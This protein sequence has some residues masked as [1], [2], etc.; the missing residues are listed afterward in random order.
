MRPYS[1]L[2]HS[3][4]LTNDLCAAR[5]I[6][7]GSCDNV[8]CIEDLRCASP[9]SSLLFVLYLTRNAFQQKSFEVLTTRRDDRDEF[10]QFTFDTT[11]GELCVPPSPAGLFLFVR[12]C[13][14]RNIETR[15]CV[16]TPTLLCI[17]RIS[18]TAHEGPPAAG[19][20]L[21]VLLK[22]QIYIQMGYPG[23]ARRAITLEYCIVCSPS[24]VL[25]PNPNKEIWLCF[26][27]RRGHCIVAT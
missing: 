17:A 19:D 10:G 15:I 3:P 11:G 6:W 14:Y 8:L 22:L 16:S 20:R 4:L 9:S 27:G 12:I 7:G 21:K 18:T 23:A 13:I 5:S 25:R 26:L 2:P 1:V 24:N